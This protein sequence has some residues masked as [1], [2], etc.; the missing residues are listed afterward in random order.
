MHPRRG[1]GVEQHVQRRG[2]RFPTDLLRSAGT[3]QPGAPL[4]GRQRPPHEHRADRLVLLALRA[5]HPGLPVIAFPRGAG[6]RFADAHAARGAPCVALDDGAAPEWAAKH[7]Q[8]H[9]CVQGNLA[10]RHLVTGGEALV[11]ETR[12][13][14]QAFRGRPHV[15]NLGHG[16]TPDAT[17]ENVHRMIETVRGGQAS[18]AAM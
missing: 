11:H 7:V 15:F 14:V 9:G 4:P 16:I 1:Q 12:R 18:F 5:R 2:G 17:I 13:V 8:S 10:S 6:E 3:R